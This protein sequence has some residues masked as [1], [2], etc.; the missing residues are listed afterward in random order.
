MEICENIIELIKVYRV[1]HFIVYHF[2]IHRSIEY[3]KL[4]KIQKHIS[5]KKLN[6][7]NL[8]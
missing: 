5:N 6:F 2:I 7:H 8:T 3:S 4:L 1:S